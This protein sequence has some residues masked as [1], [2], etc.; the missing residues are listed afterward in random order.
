MSLL[1]FQP[2]SMLEPTGQNVIP[3]RKSEIKLTAVHAGLSELLK[4]CQTESVLS[5][6]KPDKTDCQLKIWFHAVLHAETD[7]MEEIPVQL[8]TGTKEPESFLEIFTET[9]HSANHTN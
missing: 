5:L 7:V 4:L 8:G 3:S 1:T 9:I 6:V 2:L